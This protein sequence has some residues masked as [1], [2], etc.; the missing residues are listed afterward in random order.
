MDGLVL[1]YKEPGV[2]SRQVTNTI[3]SLFKEKKVGHLGTLDP[4]AEGLLPVFLGKATKI[5]P[6]IDDSKKT[7]LACLEL[8][9]NTDTQDNTGKVVKSSPIIE[10][11]DCQIIDAL[12]VVQGKERQRIPLLSAK[13]YQ[14]ERLYDMYREGKPTPK[15]LE[16]DIK[17]Y[18]LSLVRNEGKWISF[19]ATVSKGTYI[20]QL[21]EDIASELHTCGHLVYLQREKIGVFDLNSAKKISEITKKDI[22]PIVDIDFGFSK[23]K[24]TK[25]IEKYVL[26]GNKIPKGIL[27]ETTPEKVMF[28]K[29]DEPIA[30]YQKEDEG[31]ICLRGL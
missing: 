27:K 24:L 30:L 31:Y 1:V 25:D 6:Y 19:R 11:N 7:Y 14:G 5:I 22:I 21:G 16:K 15:N 2:T 20:R 12:L 17:I 28:I 4:F 13:H 18:S 26:N 3:S 10:V 23:V 8:G 9:E 29:D